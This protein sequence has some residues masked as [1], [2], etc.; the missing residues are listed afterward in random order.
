MKHAIGAVFGLVVFASP[1]LGDPESESFLQDRIAALD[2]D[3]DWTATAGAIASEGRAT[4]V[5]ELAIGIPSPQATLAAGEIRIDDLAP[6]EDDSFSF[7]GGAI[8]DLR[9]ES[10][11][12]SLVVPNTKPDQPNERLAI[13]ALDVGGVEFFDPARFAA[14]SKVGTDADP[15]TRD[16]AMREAMRAMPKLGQFTLRNLTLG[17]AEPLKL[18]SLSL[19]VEEYLGPVPLPWKAEMTNLALPGLYLR[20]AL[21]RV[22]PRVAQV[23][24]LF[25]DKIFTIDATGGEVWENPDAGEVRASA[26]IT[27]NDGANIELTYSYS[28]VTED[29]LASTLSETLIGDLE[30]GLNSFESGVK[31]K[32]LTLR[33]SDRSLLDELF[34]AVAAELRLGVDGAAYRQQISSLALPLF[35]LA[36]GRPEFVDML[37]QP[38]Q[39]FLGSGK[40]LVVQ[41]RPSAPVAAAEIADA[42][43]GDPS[44]LVA[45]LNLTVSTEDSAALQ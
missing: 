31:L 41:V 43:Q 18:E 17:N 34:G 45:L 24:R 5:R 23:L 35:M 19:E 1:A 37:L 26:R 29:W 38:L 11:F 30:K 14:L 7:A 33:I 44:K 9:I 16:A 27:I 25:D 4:I 42:L 13:G 40:T 22:E 21:R 10:P 15:A 36:L 2:S 39:E 12:L 8:S 3:P 20:S 6:A 32:A 28:G